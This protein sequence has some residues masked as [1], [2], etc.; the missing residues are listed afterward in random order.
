MVDTGAVDRMFDDVEDALL[1][2]D[3]DLDEIADFAIYRIQT[4][5]ELGRTVKGRYFK[6]YRPSTRRNRARR[7]REVK[8]V[9]LQDTGKMMASMRGRAD[10]GDALVYFASRE[11]GRKAAWLDE[12]TSTMDARPFMGMSQ[13]DL[14]EAAELVL[15]RIE[16][17]IAG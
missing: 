2:T 7:G 9:T 14:D 16:A 10:E 4:R 6:A 17:R 12:G 1:I 13:K 5:T 15:E 8:R 11:E 3:A